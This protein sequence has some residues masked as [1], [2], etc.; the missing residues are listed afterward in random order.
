ME[1]IELSDSFHSEI[2][3]GDVEFILG[4]AILSADKDKHQK[5][6][7]AGLQLISYATKFGKWLLSKELKDNLDKIGNLINSIIK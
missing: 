6:S 2:E 1:L 7:F 5:I 3:K 4:E